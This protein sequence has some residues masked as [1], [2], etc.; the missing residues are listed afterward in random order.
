MTDTEIN[1]AALQALCGMHDKKTRSYMN[2]PHLKGGPDE[3]F[4]GRKG[5]NH[6]NIPP[7]PEAY[8]YV[9]MYTENLVRMLV[10]AR[11]HAKC[12]AEL[13]NGTVGPPNYSRVFSFMDAGCG[14]GY[15]LDIAEA[16]GF[17]RREGVELNPAHAEFAR[18]EGRTVHTGDMLTF[19]FS[20]YSVVYSY[21]P[22]RPFNRFTDRLAKEAKVGTLFVLC[23]GFSLPN[24]G[25]F[26][27]IYNKSG[28]IV[29]KT[30]V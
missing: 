17:D 16:V 29:R 15:T 21:V 14:P 1:S 12:E 5:V 13:N 25:Q 26:E 28:M 30:G 27:V 18:S 20:P 23:G 4:M 2:L 11:K 24:E 19:D 7:M 6:K 9:P 8:P 3:E 22:I 10:F